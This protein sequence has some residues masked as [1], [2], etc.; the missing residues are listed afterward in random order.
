M[1]YVCLVQL[2]ARLVSFVRSFALSVIIFYML[3]LIFITGPNTQY[4]NVVCIQFCSPFVKFHLQ[5]SSS[6]SFGRVY[7]SFLSFVALLFYLLF[8]Y[9]LTLAHTKKT[10]EEKKIIGVPR[11]SF[12]QL[13]TL[14][15]CIL[16]YIIYFIYIVCVF[17]FLQRF[18]LF[19]CAH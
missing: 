19:T 11:S 18:V 13:T 15:F 10:K 12:W 1:W 4:S 17:F 7:F 14:A 2:L 6:F 8:A 3:C 9:L 5:L 16:Y